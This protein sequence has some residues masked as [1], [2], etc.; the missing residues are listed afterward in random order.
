[1]LIKGYYSNDVFEFNLQKICKYVID[2]FLGLDNKTI[3][4]W[5]T[6]NIR[7]RKI[8]QSKGGNEIEK[9]ISANVGDI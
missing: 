1:M 5:V 6:I 9:N 4:Y 3:S 2:K 7:I 8:K